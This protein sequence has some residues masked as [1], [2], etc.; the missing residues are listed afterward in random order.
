MEK[1]YNLKGLILKVVEG[2]LT[3]EDCEAIV[4]PANSLLVMG[5]GVAGAIK[6]KGGEDIEREA[7]KKA[8]VPVGSAVTTRAGRLKAKYV[9]H[10]PTMEKP[11]MKISPENVYEATRAAL[12]EA[13][14]LS[15]E[16]I[17]FPAMGAGVG[18]VPIER[19]VE[20]MFKALKDLVEE[21]RISKLKTVR[22]VA[23]GTEAYNKFLTTL[24]KLL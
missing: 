17:A 11:A 18:G 6:R 13:E 5:G 20:N 10:A 4:N 8:P 14:K 23:W 7:R 9:I 22:F 16:C 12:L 24:S 15:V 21:G 3:E 1:S 19:A 2:D